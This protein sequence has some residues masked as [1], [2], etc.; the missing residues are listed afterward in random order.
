M[1]ARPLR[2]ASQ[3]PTMMAKSVAAQKRGHHARIAAPNS[4]QRSTRPP[5]KKQVRTSQWQWWVWIPISAGVVLLSSLIAVLFGAMLI[6]NAS[7]LPGVQV[8]DVALGGLSESEA[9]QKLN[10]EWDSLTLRDG[11]RVWSVDALAI[12]VMLD[13]ATTAEQALTQGRQAGLQA[14]T[15]SVDIAPVVLVNEG[16]LRDELTR[17]GDIINIAAVNAG[18]TLVN[19]RVQATPPQN[20]RRLDVAATVNQFVANPA[21]ELTDGAFDLVMQSVTPAVTDASHIV[22]QAEA[23]L[24]HP[25]DMRVFDPVSGDSMY[26]SVA[27]DDWGQWLVASPNP[28]SPV[29]L[30]LTMADAPLRAYLQRQADTLGGSRTLDMDAAAAAIQRAIQSGRPPQADVIVMHTAR[31]HTVQAGESITSIAW[32]YG[33]PYLYIIQANGGIE[34]VNVGQQITIPAADAFLLEPVVADKRIVVS[35]SQQKTWVYENGAL[36]WEW[37]SSTG[38]ADSPTWPGVYQVISKETNAYAGNWDLWMPNFIGVYQPVPNANFTN[39]F[40][41]F[42]TRGG[43]QLLWEN[44][45]GRRVTYGCI[46]VN[47]V[48]SQ[49]LFDWAEIGVVVEILP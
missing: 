33:I 30:S 23:L 34:N 19:G 18:V 36:K 15:G 32:D 48:N 20:G 8:G 25:L 14:L 5:A 1:P 6:F 35:I 3:Q 44:S 38:I 49:L 41:G 11:E 42:P 45:L 2:P 39:G 10:R 17:M 21:A 12:G 29:G 7:I 16:A 40:H 13:A 22:A 31:T 47:N 26:W 4:P 24:S 27:P 28:D 9:A 46:L 43:G 37:L